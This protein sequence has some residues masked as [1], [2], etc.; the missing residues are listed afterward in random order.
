MIYLFLAFFVIFALVIFWH[1]VTRKYINPYTLTIF[2][3][4]KG[5]GK[6]TLLQKLAVYYSKR[7]YNVYCNVGDSD[8]KEANKIV[9]TDLPQLAEAGHQ[10]QHYNNSLPAESLRRQYSKSGLTVACA[11]KQP[12]VILCDEINL[13]WDNRNFKNFSPDLQKYFRLQRHYKHKFIAF[14][15]TF[16]CDKKIRDLAD[17]LYIVSRF[18]R[19]FIR[20][21]GYYKKVVVVSPSEDNSR[22]TANMTDDFIPM[23]FFSDLFSPFHAWLPKWV[24]YHDSFK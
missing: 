18:A 19:V 4:K 2:F 11:I 17:A 23:G 14:S 8:L 20:A 5:C 3:G 10:L 22:E 12:A 21:K 7:G 1:L 9:I 6:S 15:Q 24:K 16:D 13:L